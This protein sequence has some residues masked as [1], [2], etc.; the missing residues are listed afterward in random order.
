VRAALDDPEFCRRLAKLVAMLSADNPA[1]A[2]AARQ[3]LRAHLATRQL[4]MLDLAQRLVAG[5]DAAPVQVPALEDALRRSRAETL[6]A[7]QRATSAE[8][9]L[10]R[11]RR[12][13]AARGGWMAIAALAALAAVG[14]AAVGGAVLWSWPRR[15]IPGLPMSAAS[16]PP[17]LPERGAPEVEPIRPG[18]DRRAADRPVFSWQPEPDPGTV[19]TAPSARSAFVRGDQTPLRERASGAAALRALL[20]RHL[21]VVV[22]RTERRGGEDWSLVQTSHGRGYVAAAAIT[23]APR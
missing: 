21:P 12:A 6:A 23:A 1:E 5:R 17:L 10:A 4:S 16:A 3:K 20:P 14:G 8:R 18:P 2:E 19:P 11:R 15:P 22:I 13:D 9:V 7:L